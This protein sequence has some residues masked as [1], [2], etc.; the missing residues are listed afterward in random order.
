M[1]AQNATAN[2]TPSERKNKKTRRMLAPLLIL[3]VI[4]LLVF[5]MRSGIP[6]AG[7]EREPAETAPPT[8]ASP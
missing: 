4:A 6:S 2:E 1:T 3:A 8:P 7:I 5:A